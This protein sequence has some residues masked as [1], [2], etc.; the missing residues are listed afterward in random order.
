MISTEKKMRTTGGRQAY[1]R[2][3]TWTVPCR[4]APLMDPSIHAR[5]GNWRNGGEETLNFGDYT[6]RSGG[7]SKTSNFG[8][9][10]FHFKSVWDASMDELLGSSR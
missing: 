6:G 5:G 3:E 10:N 8:E 4:I 2:P 9:P 7:G 1:C